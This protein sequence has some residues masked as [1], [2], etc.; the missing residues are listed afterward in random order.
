MVHHCCA[1]G[2]RE[3]S[4]KGG[5]VTLHSFPKDPSRRK[6]WE[7]KVRRQNFKVT[8]YTKI[9]SKHFTDDCFDREKFGGTWLKSDAVPTLFNF[10][11]HVLSPS[12]D[13]KPRKQ[14]IPLD[15]SSSA[16]SCENQ[17]TRKDVDSKIKDG[18]AETVNPAKADGCSSGEEVCLVC[19]CAIPPGFAINLNEPSEVTKIILLQHL[20][21]I[22]DMKGTV[23][24]IEVV[25]RRC[26]SLLNYIDRTEEEMKVLKGAISMCILA[27]FVSEEVQRE[28]DLKNGKLILDKFSSGLGEKQYVMSLEDIFSLRIEKNAG[29][30][31]RTD[32]SVAQC[33]KL[34]KDNQ[35]SGVEIADV[36]IHT[37]LNAQKQTDD[38]VA[39]VVLGVDKQART[40]IEE[41]EGY[42]EAVMMKDDAGLVK[43]K[44]TM[45]IVVQD[46]FNQLDSVGKS[47]GTQ[48]MIIELDEIAPKIPSPNQISSVVQVVEDSSSVNEALLR[49]TKILKCKICTFKTI[50]VAVMIWHLRGHARKGRRCDYCDVNLPERRL[51]MPYSKGIRSGIESGSDSRVSVYEAPDLTES[52]VHNYPVVEVASSAERFYKHVCKI[53]SFKTDY[54]SVMIWHLRKHMKNCLECDYCSENLPPCKSLRQAKYVQR[55]KRESRSINAKGCAAMVT[56]NEKAVEMLQAE[57]SSTKGTEKKDMKNGISTFISPVG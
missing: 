3:R 6:L 56:I 28:N 11:S 39:M 26:S 15:G 13:R 33:N 47:L 38:E 5:S 22:V 57:E 53:C 8:D 40:P 55:R 45:A 17:G 43:D 31:V 21:S 46:V 41:E 20:E 44:V 54:D 35:H 16:E 34:Q 1:Y 2:C 30:E 52:E 49:S 18:T 32:G 51:C 4:Q 25:C 29:S 23:A 12:K 37:D 19:R 42:M 27:K 7:M 36:F 9:C 48:K 24:D 14:I 10:T 50:Y